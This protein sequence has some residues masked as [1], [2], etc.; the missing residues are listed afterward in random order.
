MD[1]PFNNVPLN[2]NR[3]FVGAKDKW[4]CLI[5]LPVDTVDADEQDKRKADLHYWLHNEQ[6]P[7]Q[8]PELA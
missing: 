6:F 7:A 4:G 3:Q 8:D 5:W 2:R 1:N